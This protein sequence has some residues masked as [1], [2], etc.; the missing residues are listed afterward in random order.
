MR[1]KQLQKS[2]FSGCG[3][4]GLLGINLEY[5]GLFGLP[6]NTPDY[7][8]LPLITADI[9]DYGGL[10]G[11]LRIIR[12]TPICFNLLQI[13]AGYT[14]LLG[15]PPI[16]SSDDQVV[17]RITRVVSSSGLPWIKRIPKCE[18]SKLIIRHNIGPTLADNSWLL[19]LGQCRRLHR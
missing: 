3:L 4:S 16:K 18:L 8:E 5:F 13:T 9:S 6:W 19:L 15:L 1:G 14:G 11:L 2:R 10:L 17:Q 12:I 7:T